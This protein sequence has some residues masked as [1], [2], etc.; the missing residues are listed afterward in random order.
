MCLLKNVLSVFQMV[1][2]TPES[3]DAIQQIYGV[4]LQSCGQ[5]DCRDSAKISNLR[6]LQ[7]SV[8]DHQRLGSQFYRSLVGSHEHG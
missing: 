8:L 2:E 4:L 5:W 7:L 1:T 3:I 6:Q